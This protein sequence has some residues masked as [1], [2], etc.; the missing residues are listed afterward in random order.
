[1]LEDLILTAATLL[2]LA[3]TVVYEVSADWNLPGLLR[4]SIPIAIAIQRVVAE[5]NDANY[6][7]LRREPSRAAVEQYL[8]DLRRIDT[9]F[10]PDDF[11]DALRDYIRGFGGQLV[12][13]DLKDDAG[14]RADNERTKL[15]QAAMDRLVRKYR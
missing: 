14:A 5:I 2:T 12:S 1:M 4:G 6:A 10:A 8:E 3:G 11:Q 9:G 7:R 13:Y 15:A